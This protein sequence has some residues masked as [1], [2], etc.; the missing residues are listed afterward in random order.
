MQLPRKISL[1]V[2]REIAV[3]VDGYK[4]QKA[5]GQ[6]LGHWSNKLAHT[7]PN[8]STHELVSWG[9]VSRVSSSQ[10]LHRATAE[11]A[12]RISPGLL[13]IESLPISDDLNGKPSSHKLLTPSSA[14]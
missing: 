2:S 10:L 1:D 3:L 13:F 12:L 5:M 6:F 9:W 8:G 4:L 14:M 11:L 7:I